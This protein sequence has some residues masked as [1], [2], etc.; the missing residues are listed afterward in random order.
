[1]KTVMIA[2]VTLREAGKVS[3]H[4]S[5]RE[6]V[7][8]AKLLQKMGV[9]VIEVSGSDNAKTDMVFL[10]TVAPFCE[11][12]IICCPVGLGEDELRSVWN[13]LKSVKNPRLQVRVPTSTVQMEY[14]CHKKPKALAEALEKQL[15]LAV[16][17]CKDV[18]FAALDATRSEP[19]FLAAVIKTAVACGVKTVTL[20]D[21][22]G[23]MLPEEFAAF[24]KTVFGV[25]PELKNVTLSVECHNKNSLGTASALAAISAGATQIKTAVACD[26]V[27]SILSVAG[28]L[29]EKGDYLAVKTGLNY[30]LLGHSV[31]KL[32]EMLT[33]RRSS[34][35]PFDSGVRKITED[36]SLGKD[37]DVNT[38]AKYIATLGYELS[39]EDVNKVYERFVQL[40]EKKRIGAKE[41]DAIVASNAMQV[42]PTYKCISYVIN[43]GNVLTA[44]AN[45]VLEKDGKELKGISLGDGPIDAAFLAI[46]QI[47]CRHYEL[48]DFQIQSVTQGKEAVGEALVKLR[49]SGKLYS[50]RGISTD[51]IGAS[52]RA[53]INALN[54]ICFENS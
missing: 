31:E 30:A 19:E 43:C 54:K 23:D 9:D 50:G 3:E 47:T 38:V 33:G 52:I 2:D 25:A 7:E 48:D 6:K 22:A 20:C 42:P 16:S 27:T 46:E 35:S 51:I 12:K 24:I 32:T 39:E 10:H 41:L 11:G 49:Y 14:V 1:M 5:F 36:F 28:V 37:D 45:V 29:K 4:V 40:A 15:K 53:Y 17:L 21:S 8:S 18:E 26:N 13:A 44:T 34:T